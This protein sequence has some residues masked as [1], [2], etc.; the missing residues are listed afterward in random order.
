MHVHAGLL[1]LAR[2]A[3]RS[4]KRRCTVIMIMIT[5]RHHAVEDPQ[6]GFHSE[7]APPGAGGSV[8]SA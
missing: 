5:N 8:V 6:G 3:N 2:N 4:G 1:R 7:G